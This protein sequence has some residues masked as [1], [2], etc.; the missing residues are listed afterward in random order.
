MKEG[1]IIL[2]DREITPIEFNWSTANRSTHLPQ[3][4]EKARLGFSKGNG[5]LNGS[6][7]DP[8]DGTIVNVRAVIFQKQNRA[9]GHFISRKK[10]AFGHF[11]L[12]TIAVP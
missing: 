2:S 11:I 12:E 1:G 8:S 3:D 5:L 10:D 9:G 6:Y 7:L 4:T